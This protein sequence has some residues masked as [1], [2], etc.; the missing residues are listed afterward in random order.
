M[1]TASALLDRYEHSLLGVFGR[2]KLVLERGAGDYVWDVDGTRYLDLLGGLAVNSLGHAHP[3]VAAAIAAQAGRLMHTSN[4]FTTPGQ[5][6]LAER[7]LTLAQAPADSAVFFANSGTEAIEAAIKLARRTGR[8][9]LLATQGA[10]HG[11]TTGALALTHK[12]AYREP[13]APLL[14]DV[15]PHIPYHD[16]RA[17]AAAFAEHG[18]S[19]GAF[20]VEPIQGEAGVLPGDDS[21]LQL[22]RELTTK[23]GA[24]LIV[25]EIQTGIGRTGRWFGFQRA[26]IT[27]DAITVAKGLGGGFPIGALITFGP[28]VTGML[29]AGQHG[30]TF[31]GNPLACAAG[32][33]VLTVIERDGVL[34]HVQQVGAKLRD[35]VLGLP[36]G[37]VAE[38]RGEGLLLGIGLTSLTAPAIAAR[39]QDAGYIVNAVREDTIRLAPSLLLEPAHAEDF[40]GALPGLLSESSE[41]A[42]PVGGQGTPSPPQ[43]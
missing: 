33:A 37:R 34:Q 23:H 31:G 4:F 21:Y 17:L 1:T 43:D 3:E 11:R 42:G 16:S 25:D 6:A 28:A 38:V 8:S 30:T 20:I 10:F 9:G 18:D 32:L 7:L 36:G 19:I 24:L 40:L 13:F 39:A 22:A 2:P 26:G 12:P 41:A 5:V 35:G 14:P 29:T 27:P 15:L